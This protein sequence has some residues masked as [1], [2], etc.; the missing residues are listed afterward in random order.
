MQ[1]NWRLKAPEWRKQTGPGFL[2]SFSF[3]FVLNNILQSTSTT[4][5]KENKKLDLPCTL[6][7]GCWKKSRM[8][9]KHGFLLSFT[10]LCNFIIVSSINSERILILASA[11]SPPLLLSQLS[12]SP[13]RAFQHPTNHR[14]SEEEESGRQSWRWRDASKA[15]P[16]RG[17]TTG[18]RPTSPWSCD[19]LRCPNLPSAEKKHANYPEQGCG[20]DHLRPTR[21]SYSLS[22]RSHTLV[23]A[24]QAGRGQVSDVQPSSNTIET[25][26]S[27]FES[28]VDLLFW[29]KPFF[30]PLPF[31]NSFDNILGSQKPADQSQKAVLCSFEYLFLF[32]I[33]KVQ[34]Q[35][36]WSCS[37]IA[38]VPGERVDANFWYLAY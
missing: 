12:Q 27:P 19:D 28:C 3:L 31:P 2:L 14:R 17:H 23:A 33:G 37:R 18:Q 8:Q 5:Q 21:D 29:H 7:A 11:G 24:F 32:Q 20:R 4:S 16:A 36:T 38:T 34:L 13:V 10:S 35:N 6:E 26:L 22:T 15:H 25:F 9:L 30:P 1:R